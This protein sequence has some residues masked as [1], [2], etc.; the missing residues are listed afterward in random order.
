M[1][2]DKVAIIGLG[3]VGLPLLCD[4]AE[5]GLFVVGIDKDENKVKELQDC[6]PHIE[7]I[8]AAQIKKYQNDNLAIFTTDFAKVAECDFVVICVPTPITENKEPDLSYIVDA[9]KSIA[10][11]L[12]NKQLVCLEST[13]YPGTT[14]EIFIP[15]IE[16]HCDFKY[17]KDFFVAY[18]PERVDPGNQEFNVHNT[19]RVVGADD[20]VSMEK[21]KK[22]YAYVTTE[23]H[24]VSSLACAEAVKI[25]ENVYRSVNIALVNE[26]K[27][28]YKEMGI[29]AWEVIDAAKTKPFGYTAFYPGPGIGGHCIP[30]DPYYLTWKS[31]IYDRTARFIELAGEVNSR[32]PYYV[33]DEV[34]YVLNNDF[35]KPISGS[36]ILV[37][38][39]SYKKNI[40]DLRNSPSLKLISILKK[41]KADITVFDP[42]V[43]PDFYAQHGG[44]GQTKL[45]NTI[46]D[47]DIK[48]YDAVIVATDHDDV[49]YQ[50]IAQNAK[51]VFDT[52][53][54]M[55]DIKDRKNIYKV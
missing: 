39:L 47:K 6:N 22:F 23:V 43:D 29:D 53:N 13:T 46:S 32:M 16:A 9:G 15:A 19:P 45:V 50:M 41:F 36:K 26:L 42:I 38:G 30:V 24:P 54:V 4:L 18:A 8:T 49:D 7:G 2:Q 34:S 12:S 5:Q 48:N 35:S 21:A 17:G 51:A 14:R 27:I 20:D 33:I 31:R 11:Y 52:K 25:T 44:K 28:I 10:P 3:Y 37:V 1:S 55:A 40:S